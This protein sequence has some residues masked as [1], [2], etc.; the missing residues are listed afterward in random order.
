M[1]TLAPPFWMDYDVKHCM[2]N[3]TFMARELIE[4]DILESSLGDHYTM[5]A[6]KTLRLKFEYHIIWVHM[7]YIE[8]P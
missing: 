1:I 7:K 2:V 4:V 3:S 5:E 6:F 8:E